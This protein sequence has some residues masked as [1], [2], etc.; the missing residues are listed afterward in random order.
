MQTLAD[1]KYRLQGSP[2]P[3]FSTLPELV[4]FHKK[5]KAGLT[6]TL[7]EPCPQEHKPMAPDLSKE[8]S[9]E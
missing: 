4:A 8:V 7:K 1:N 5:K 3:A 9:L 2:S 6:T